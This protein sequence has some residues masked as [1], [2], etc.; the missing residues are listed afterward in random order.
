MD[1]PINKFTIFRE[2]LDYMA[3]IS[4]VTDADMNWAGGSVR[5][6]GRTGGQEICIEVTIK[7]KEEKEK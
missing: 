3:H 7:Y 4:D 1:T 6:T 2:M 5:I